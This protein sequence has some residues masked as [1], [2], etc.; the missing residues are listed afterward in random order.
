MNRTKSILAGIAIVGVGAVA[1]SLMMANKAKPPK[2]QATATAPL[3]EV[4][5]PKV[6]DVEFS[7][8]AHGLVMP[9]TETVLVSEV[10]GVVTRVS[11][12]FVAGGLF[13]KDEVILQ[14]DPSDYEVGVE[15]AK[16]RLAS[17]M[18][19]YEQ[20]KARSEQAEKEW[21]LTGRSRDNAPVLALRK[22]FLLEAKANM[23]SAEADLKKAE[24]KLARTVIRAPY[25]GMVKSKKVDVGQFVSMGTQ[26]GESFAID[27]AEVRLPLTDQELAYIDVPA[28]GGELK[29]Q[30]PSVALTASYAGNEVEWQG[31]IVRMEGIVDNLSRVH[32]AVARITDPYNISLNNHEQPPLKIGTFV[33]A[34]IQGK[35]MAELIKLPRDAFRDLTKVL[36]SDKSNQL[37]LRELNVVRSES[38]SVYVKAGLEQGDRIVMTSIESPV[39]GMKV[40]VQGDEPLDT[41]ELEG[42]VEEAYAQKVD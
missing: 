7:V 38:E 9:R 31:K 36:V 19:K 22:P 3:V 1:I 12:K 26:L 34:S 5:V 41:E 16:A 24:Q 8:K 39:E 21:D 30:M 23:Q 33:S 37:F 14:I 29:G 42:E 17:Q 25:Q 27:Y 2:K 40:R 11:D 18:A 15:Q 28:W 20:E 10:S 13:D 32:Y 6:E 35:K 4:V